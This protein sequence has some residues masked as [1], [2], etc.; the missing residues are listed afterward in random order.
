MGDVAAAAHGAAAETGEEFDKRIARYKVL[1][2]DG[3]EEI[4][5]N[6]AVGEHHAEREQ[7]AVNGP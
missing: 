4:E 6:I 5:E 3:K 1:C 2:L 7:D